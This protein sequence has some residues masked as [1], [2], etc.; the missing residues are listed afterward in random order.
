MQPVSVSATLPLV[1]SSLGANATVTRVM[2]A[3]LG[4]ILADVIRGAAVAGGGVE[5]IAELR[6]LDG[7]GE[8]I[9]RNDIDVVV[10]AVPEGAGY[11][12]F[13]GVLAD[14]PRTRVVALEADGRRGFLHTPGGCTRALGEPSLDAL[15]EIVR[16][17]PRASSTPAGP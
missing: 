11:E 4:G 6:S 13:A 16:A 7:L 14:H 2:L 17:V 9:G 3:A 8:A 15:V 1:N 10:C 12:L 5:V